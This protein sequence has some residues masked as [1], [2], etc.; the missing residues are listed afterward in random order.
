MPL[1]LVSGGTP[2]LLSHHN[3]CLAPVPGVLTVV[4][5]VVHGQKLGAGEVPLRLF[6]PRRLSIVNPTK[7][8][9]GKMS[10]E[11][12]S[13]QGAPMSA[14]PPPPGVKQN[15]INPPQTAGEVYVLVAVGVAVSGSLL[16]MRLYTKGIILR[17][18]GW[19]DCESKH[20]G[21]S[22]ATDL[23]Q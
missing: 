16:I 15:F 22:T 1:H 7:S 14:V 10:A 11:L 3:R 13:R 8:I 20:Y 17:K 9:D 2:R 5:S 6:K 23:A 21:Q 4:R 12:L 19:E 18:F